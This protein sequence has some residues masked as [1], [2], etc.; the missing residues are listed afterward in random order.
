MKRRW[1]K[2]RNFALRDGRLA[3]SHQCQRRRRKKA[4]V[5]A[6]AKASIDVVAVVRPMATKMHHCWVAASNVNW[7]VDVV[8]R[9]PMVKKHP[10]GDWHVASVVLRQVQAPLPRERS[11]LPF[12]CL[13]RFVNFR[14]PLACL[15]VRFS[16]SS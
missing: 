11:E 2:R 10:N 14:K 13:A 5:A 9:R 1:K 3:H 16:R 7:H 8:R 15:R 12:N 6:A 4:N